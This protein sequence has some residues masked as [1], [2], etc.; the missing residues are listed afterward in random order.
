MD[1]KIFYFMLVLMLIEVV[2][3]TWPM[4]YEPMRTKAIHFAGRILCLVERIFPLVLLMLITI[5][6]F[7]YI[8]ADSP[9]ERIAARHMILDGV[10]GGFCIL[11]LFAVA[12]T[13][14]I[15]IY[16]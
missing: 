2:A 5:G 11:V 8:L 6:G 4:S 16:C 10:I 1:K 13:F 15:P 14:G 3:A 12:E 7:K 9:G